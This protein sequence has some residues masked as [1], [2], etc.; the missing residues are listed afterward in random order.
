MDERVK[1]FGDSLMNLIKD[2]FKKD[3]NMTKDSKEKWKLIFPISLKKNQQPQLEKFIR[4]LV[5]LVS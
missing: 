2:N 5:E 1:Q 3:K 4:N